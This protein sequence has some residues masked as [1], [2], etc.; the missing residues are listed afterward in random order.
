MCFGAGGGDGDT[1]LVPRYTLKYIYTPTK[2][3][4]CASTHITYIHTHIPTGDVHVP[5]TIIMH[6]SLATARE[7]GGLLHEEWRQILV[8]VRVFVYEFCVHVCASVCV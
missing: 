6:L 8:C 4:T 3:Y 5:I 1:Q 7:R 2:A